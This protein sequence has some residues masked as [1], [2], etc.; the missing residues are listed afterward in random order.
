MKIVR[1]S[2]GF[3]AESQTDQVEQM[4]NNEFKNSL[5]PTIQKL[6]GNVSYDVGIDRQ[7][8][9]MTNVSVWESLEDAMQMATLPEM[10]AM[11]EV[12][13]SLGIRF[14]DITN[15]QVLWELP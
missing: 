5:I 13:E 4:L 14:I 9:A 11:R 10:L 7:K 1:I 3:F 6:H 2:I 8:Y 15:Y 12:F